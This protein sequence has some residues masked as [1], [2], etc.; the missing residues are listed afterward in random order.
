VL[1]KMKTKLEDYLASIPAPAGRS[2]AG[3]KKE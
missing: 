3:K 1:A 2:A